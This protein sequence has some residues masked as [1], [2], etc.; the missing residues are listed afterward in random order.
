MKKIRTVADLHAESAI[1]QYW[2]EIITGGVSVGK[3]VRMLYEY[4]VHGMESGE[5]T[6]DLRKSN[7][8]IRWIQKHC[9]HTEGDLAPELSGG[10][11]EIRTDG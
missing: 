2:N 3:W 9:F 7:H 5:F 11:A 4:I 1:L 10:V 6:H 8:A